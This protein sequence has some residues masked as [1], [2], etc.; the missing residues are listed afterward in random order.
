MRPRAIV[1]GLDGLPWPAW[2][3]VA[4]GSR[5]EGAGGPLLSCQPPVTIPAWAVAATGKTPG[6][7]GLYGL[8]VPD[9]PSMKPRLARPDD[10]RAEPLWLDLR[11]ILVGFP[12][13]YP[14]APLPRGCRVSCFLT[15]PGGAWASPASLQSELTAVV[16]DYI[17]D[18]LYRRDDPGAAVRDARAMAAAR[19]RIAAHIA[20]TRPWDLL[21][22]VEMGSD[23]LQHALGPGHPAVEEH[24]RFA[25]ECAEA[26]A[27]EHPDATLLLMSDHGSEPARG[28]FALN[29]WLRSEGHLGLQEEPAPGAEMESLADPARTSAWAWGGYWGKVFVDGTR[30][31]LRDDIADALEALRGPPGFR[32]RVHRPEE[33]YPVCRGRPPGLFVEPPP[34]WRVGG[35]VGHP[36]LFLDRNDTGPDGAV[37]SPEGFFHLADPEGRGSPGLRSLTD[38]APFLKEV[39]AG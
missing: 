31:T 29:D 27:A 24:A 32:L 4:R 10:V 5:L 38:V 26:L 30:A 18:I 14:P 11:T 1:I 37:H 15:P 35:T 21:W 28:V 9:G 6:E 25:V 33:L 13:G 36:S 20:R 34:G 7:I 16:G 8:R 39:L 17:P 19:F 22:L 3:R 12:P 2:K 23:R